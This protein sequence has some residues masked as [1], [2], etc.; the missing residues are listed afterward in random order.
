MERRHAANRLESIVSLRFNVS[1]WI[2]CG[3]GLD[4]TED[5]T[6]W[7][8]GPAPQEIN[9]HAQVTLPPLLRRRVTALG[10]MAFKAALDLSKLESARFIFCS[11]HGEFQRTLSILTALATAEP[12]SPAEFSLSVHNA[13]AGLLS[14]AQHNTAGHTAIAAGAE[15]FQAGLIEAASCLI[16]Q[17]D[18]P[19][20]LVYYDDALPIPYGELADSSET[21]L[22][23]AM[24]LTAAREEGEAII[25][26]LRACEESASADAA[27][28]KQARA[29]VRF[30]QSPKFESFGSGHFGWRR[31]G[32]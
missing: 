5:Q 21:C 11:R 16:D 14:I 23:L 9:G 15:S 24:L 31:S 12:V 26:E 2:A 22:A 1:Q 18:Q 7:V 28:S 3:V 25:L 4:A 30:L 29:F 6:A 17:P 13:L 8:R 32:A 27:A 19:V 10:Q 20:L